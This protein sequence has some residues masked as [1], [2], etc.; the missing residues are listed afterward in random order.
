MQRQAQKPRGHQTAGAQ[1][2][3]AQTLSAHS[4]HLGQ[5]HDGLQ[6]ERWWRAAWSLDT[7]TAAGLGRRDD[8]VVQVH[9]NTSPAQRPL[10]KRRPVRTTAG[11]VAFFFDDAPT[12]SEGGTS[13]ALEPMQKAAAFAC[14]ANTQTSHSAPRTLTDDMG[15]ASLA[16]C[17]Q[18]SRRAT[19]SLC[20]EMHAQ[21]DVPFFRSL[22]RYVAQATSRQMD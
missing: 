22:A 12:A 19:F 20:G 21:C 4:G 6:R 2:A 1:G 14:A 16:P 8:G 18:H 15:C 9:V 7:A 3:P 5:R 13:I 17:K 11:R 10:T